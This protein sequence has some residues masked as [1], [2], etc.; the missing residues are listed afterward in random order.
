MA[1]AP[2]TLMQMENSFPLAQKRRREIKSS[3]DPHKEQLQAGRGALLAAGAV[4]APPKTPGAAVP[5]WHVPELSDWN[6][7]GQAEEVWLSS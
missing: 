3:A 5:A 1:A 4:A 7:E 2:A 6:A